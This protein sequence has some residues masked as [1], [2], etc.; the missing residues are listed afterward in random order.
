MPLWKFRAALQDHRGS[1][2]LLAALAVL[3]AGT[4][5]LRFWLQPGAPPRDVALQEEAEA[6]W[7]AGRSDEAVARYREAMVM[8]EAE[9]GPDHPAFG[10]GLNN[11]AVMLISTGRYG[12]AEPLARRALEIAEDKLGRRHVGY[13][14]SLKNLGIV[15]HYLGRDA[16]ARPLYREA[17]A[18]LTDAYGADDPRTEGVADSLAQLG[19]EAPPL[20]GQT[21]D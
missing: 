19:G 1:L 18:I 8:R 11:L 6:L 14:S 16:E 13:V 21:A 3:V 12:E 20:A 7:Q 15:L 5:G 10:A 9:L 2:L 17:L 4:W